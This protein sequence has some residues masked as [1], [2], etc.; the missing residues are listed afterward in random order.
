MLGVAP[1]LDID[2]RS[3]FPILDTAKSFQEL[4]A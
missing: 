3:A 4:L 2:E 1:K